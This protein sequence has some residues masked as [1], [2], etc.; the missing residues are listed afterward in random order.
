MKATTVFKAAFDGPF[1]EGQTSTYILN[2]T[3][4]STFQNLVQYMYAN[5]I[6]LTVHGEHNTE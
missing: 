5:K 3:T 6:K 4:E 2:D 1:V